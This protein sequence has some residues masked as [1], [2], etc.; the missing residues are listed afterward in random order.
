M[1]RSGS[2]R[3][4]LQRCTAAVVRNGWLSFQRHEGNMPVDGSHGWP[5]F[6]VAKSPLGQGEVRDECSSCDSSGG[7]GY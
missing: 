5:G 7:M 1:E 6:R 4:R 2:A 3:M